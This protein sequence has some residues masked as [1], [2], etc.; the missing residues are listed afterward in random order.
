MLQEALEF[1]GIAAGPHRYGRPGVGVAMTRQEQRELAARMRVLPDRFADR[2]SASAW[3]VSG[4]RPLRA[5]GSRPSMSCWSPCRSGLSRSVRQNAPNCARWWP[6]LAWTAAVS[7]ACRGAGDLCG[8]YPAHGDTRRGNR[9]GGV[10]TSPKGR[11]RAGPAP[12]INPAIAEMM[13]LR[14]GDEW[15][16]SDRCPQ[17]AKAIPG[18]G[19]VLSWRPG[20]FTK[21]EA[22][23]SMIRVEHG[24]LAPTP[25]RPVQWRPRRHRR[26]VR[27]ASRTRT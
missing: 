25:P 21:D 24:D 22:I 20:R 8:Q 1:L 19:W 15:I 11:N 3:S 17:M 12:S 23:A 13:T 9:G 14:I 26:R 27:E 6:P 4:P 16:C 18:Q 7:T 2:L 10:R 5:A